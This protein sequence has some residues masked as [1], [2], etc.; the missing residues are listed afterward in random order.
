MLYRLRRMGQLFFTSLFGTVC[1][2]VGIVHLFKKEAS[3]QP[4]QET[5]C[6]FRPVNWIDEDESTVMMEACASFQTL[7]PLHRVPSCAEEQHNFFG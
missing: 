5:E 1:G 3:T 4:N 7:L 2:V 6:P